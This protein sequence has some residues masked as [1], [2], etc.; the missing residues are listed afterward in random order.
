MRNSFKQKIFLTSATG[1]NELALEIFYYQAKN[2]PVYSKFLHLIDIRPQNIFEI[3]EIP[4][5]PIEFFKNHQVSCVETSEQTKIFTSSSTS[6]IGIS[7]HFVPDIELYHLAFSKSFEFQ[8]GSIK[9]YTFRFLLPSY[10]E[11]KDSS[12][13]YMAEEFLKIS[14]KGGFYLNDFKKLSTDLLEDLKQKRKVILLGVSFALLD[15]AEQ[16][17][18]DLSN[19]LI[20]ETG[21][22][23]GRREEITREELHTIL[24]NKF[25]LNQITSE[26]GMTELLSQ[27][28]SLEEGIFNYPPWMKITIGQTTDPFGK[29]KPG[30]TGRIKI[31]DLANLDSCSFLSTSDLGRVFEDGSFEIL[32]RFDNSDVRGCNLMVE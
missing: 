23:K 4:Y 21:G 14:G 24:K 3:A 32:G 29:E 16:F 12:L 7:Q 11:R 19:I 27:A 2:N 20:M 18:M 15:F 25:N 17:P 1:F 22:M 5:L 9:D 8:F 13:V 26:Y 31:I 28:Y 30:K 10:L 6:G